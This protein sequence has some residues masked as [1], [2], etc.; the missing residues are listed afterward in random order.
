MKRLNRK[1]KLARSEKW[2]D[3]I[4]N[5]KDDILTE[6]LTEWQELRRHKR[7]VYNPEKFLVIFELRNVF[8]LAR[9]EVNQKYFNNIYGKSEIV[10]VLHYQ[11]LIEICKKYKKIFGSDKVDKYILEFEKLPEP[12]I[13]LDNFMREV[14]KVK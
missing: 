7:Q 9:K 3:W 12:E 1:D 13:P 10:E 11:V 8:N 2:A 4:R 6:G 5:V 14:V